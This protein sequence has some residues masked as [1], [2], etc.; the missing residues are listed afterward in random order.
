M[1]NHHARFLVWTFPYVN[2]IIKPLIIQNKNLV[3]LKKGFDHEKDVL[4]IPVAC[5]NFLGWRMQL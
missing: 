1:A 5:R 4:F 2:Y 3:F